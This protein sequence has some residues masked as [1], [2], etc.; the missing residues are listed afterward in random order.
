M[1]ARTFVTLSPAEVAA[2]IAHRTAHL[3]PAA[4][5]VVEVRWSD[6][7]REPRPVPERTPRPFTAVRTVEHLTRAEAVASAARVLPGMVQ[8]LGAG[9]PDVI[10][11]V[12][13]WEGV[14]AQAGRRDVTDPFD[15]LCA[16]LDALDLRGRAA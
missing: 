14:E 4:A 10:A 8:R 7:T 1:T 5:S 16:I 2:S 15:D 3:A 6:M 11:A 12:G 9:H 13:R